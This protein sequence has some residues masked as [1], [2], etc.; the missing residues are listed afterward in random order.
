MENY[1]EVE[2]ESLP[3]K[4]NS[5]DD[6]NSERKIRE[7]FAGY[8]YQYKFQDALDL[9]KTHKASIP[10]LINSTR[11]DS[12]KFW[13]IGHQII[14]SKREDA[15]EWV[16]KIKKC[17]FWDGARDNLGRTIYNVNKSESGGCIL[18]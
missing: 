2:L 18:M 9:V 12:S 16:E 5:L 15:N 6:W 1:A 13:T 14:H 7:K 10:N 8:A 11:P 3:P 17:G 4:Y